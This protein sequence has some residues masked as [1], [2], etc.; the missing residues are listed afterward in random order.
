M[1]FTPVSPKV[2]FVAQE[3]GV[4]RLWRETDAFA[5]LRALRQGQPHWSFIDGPITANNPMGVH[6]GWGRSYK[7]LFQRF[8]AMRGREERY[9]NGFDCQG[10]WV[11]VEVEK[12]LGFHSKKDIEDYGLA[13]FVLRCKER[14]LRSAAQQTQ[15]SIRLGYWMDWNDPDQLRRLAAKLEEDPYQAITVQGPHGPVTDTVE[16]IVGR[17]GLPELGGSYF[18]FSNENNYMIWTF[19]KKCWQNG[20]LY[21]GADVMPWCPRCATGI[22]QH[23]IV[24]DGYQELTHAAITVRF[25]LRGRPGQSLLVWTTTPWTLTSNVAAAVG[26]ELIYVKVQQHDEVVYLSKGTLHMLR[27]EYT[28]LEQLQ[29][30]EMV[31]WAYDGPFDELPAAQT[32]GGLTELRQLVSDVTATA[33]QAHRIIPWEAVGEEEG[34]GIVHIAPGCGAEDFV[35]GKEH[36]L[37]LLAPLDEEGFFLDGFGWLTGEHV[38]DAAPKIFEDLERRGRL[39]RVR[40][41]THRYPICW[42]CKTELVF[43]LVDEWF[44]SMDKLRHKMMAVTRQI[45]WIPSFGLEREL[46]WLRNMHDWMISKKRYW[47]LALPI[48]ECSACHHF[49]VIGDEVELQQRAV[50]GWETFDGHTPH[51]PFVDAV[52]IACPE[53]GAHMTRV[54]DVGNPW[55]DAGVVS[56]S[57]LQYRT[58]PDYWR[59]WYPAHW[60]SESFPG[61]FR[62]WFYSLLA[63]ATVLE[64]TPPFRENFSYATLFAEDGTPMHKSSGNMIEFNEAADRMGVDVMRWLYAQ[65]KPENNLLFGYNRADEVRRQFLIPLWNVYS[66]FVSYARLDGWEPPQEGFDSERPEGVPPRSDNLLDRWIVARIESVAARVTTML[67]ASDPTGAAVTLQELVDDLSD[68]YVRRS[69]RRFWKSEQ[70]ADKSAAYATL[71]YVLIRLCKL[72]APFT[73]FVTEGMYQNLVRAVQSAACVS[74]HHTAWSEPDASAM[75]EPLLTQ[76]ALAR[77]ICS[78]GL[79]ARNSVN[80]KVRQPLAKAKVYIEGGRGELS[81]EIA[82]IVRDELNVKAVEFVAEEGQLVSYRLAG[83]GRL[84]GPR[85]GRLYPQVRAALAALDAGPAVR[86]LRSGLS[87]TLEV[88][89]ETVELA[90]PEVL[91][92]TQPAEGLAVVADRGVTVAVDAVLTTDLVAEGLVRD[93]VRAVQTLRKDA[94]YALDQRITVGLFGLDEPLRAALAQFGDYFR[95]ETLC[96]TLL[97]EDDG[98]PWDVRSEAR[99]GQATVTLAVRR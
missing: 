82:D 31:G 9:Q 80:I 71:Y 89:G 34:T 25:P 88:A 13:R 4:L 48:W 59:E 93:L 15:Q 41:Y 14:V 12:A 36:H 24:T 11:E 58:N 79:G 32:P 3:Y 40:D 54:P 64:D 91:I 52:E 70:D 6:H 23:E 38:S 87:L 96:T 53:C 75:D 22:S 30:A 46:D 99:M 44:I 35:L 97:L 50:A 47:G 72:L 17:L 85:L 95:Q 16:Q 2:D 62:N 61:Q 27:G 39:Y 76:M 56:F 29:G 69:R 57:T 60:I 84:L 74:V 90:P 45:K 63:M 42:R 19:L 92:D 83:E 8:W 94:D 65:Q 55:L 18:T 37:P 81:P 68:W 49:E 77:R 86:R 43:R 5:K 10:L 51:R 98:A 73:P 26:P 33:A 67:E 78:L 21:R 7:D 28:V 20:W 1:P 66:F